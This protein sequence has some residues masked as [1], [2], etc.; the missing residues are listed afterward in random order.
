MSVGAS[1]GRSRALFAWSAFLGLACAFWVVR[2]HWDAPHLE[3]SFAWW[4]L[5]Q[6]VL[7]AA[8]FIRD[9]L[10]AGRLAFWNPYQL[11]GL[12]T[13]ALGMPGAAYPGNLFWLAWLE[14][15]RALE[16]STIAHWTLAGGF[17]WL[18]ARRL[19]LGGFAA[20]VA[21]LTFMLSGRLL[22]GAY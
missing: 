8:T 16:A 13:L 11:A 14:A 5:Y 10:N 20:A 3:K 12:P 22:T 1:G 18:F 2:I 15:P 17:T 7:P 19:G 4:D 21:A 9:E 6:Y